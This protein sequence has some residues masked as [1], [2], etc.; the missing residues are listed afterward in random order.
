MMA[1]SAWAEIK[2]KKIDY[3][4]GKQKL[5]GFLAYDGEQEGK[6]PGILIIHAYKGHDEY[7]QKRAV[8]LAHMGYVAFALDMYGK[9]IYAASHD[10]A[11]KMAGKFRLDN[12]LMISRATAGLNVLKKQKQVDDARLAANGMCFV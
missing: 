2:T 5:Q 6:R 10:E 9:G 7:V 1:G 11:S 3:Q 8:Q 4:H 12:T